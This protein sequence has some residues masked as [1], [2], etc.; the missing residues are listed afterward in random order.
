VDFNSPDTW[1]WI[2][3]VT[4]LVF[5]V[6]ELLSPAVFFFLPFAI[7][8]AVASVLAFLH[9][10][11]GAEWA[12]F[13]VGSGASFTGLWRLGRRL[14]HRDGGQEG[15]GATRWIGQEA[16]VIE[17]I[18]TNG[19][20]TVLLEREE[21]RAESMTGSPVRAGSTVMVMRVA[22]TRL[23]VMPVDEPVDDLPSLPPTNSG[24][25]ASGPA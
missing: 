2:W 6:G 15:V 9:V 4:A 16:R 22:G 18:N 5:V 13:V 8:A 14:E 17:P 25:P 7:G 19:I 24:G 10:P 21:W 23:V 20:G 1:R 3:A 11:I 12:I